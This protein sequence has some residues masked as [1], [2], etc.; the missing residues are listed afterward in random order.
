MSNSIVRVVGREVLDSRGR[1]TVEA[2]VHTACGVMGR[3]IAPSGAS[4]GA[5]EAIE[6]RDGDS[7]RYGGLGVLR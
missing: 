2:E 1:P 3:A 4:T 6:L 7:S 5:A